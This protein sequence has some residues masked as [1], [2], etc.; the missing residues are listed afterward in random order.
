MPARRPFG[1]GRDRRRRRPGRHRPAA[2][3]VLRR[4]VSGPIQ[5]G[6][7]RPRNGVAGPGAD[8][9]VA[10]VGVAVGTGF[11]VVVGVAPADAPPVARRPIRQR[12]LGRRSGHWK[13]L[14][15]LP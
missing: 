5:N 6:A 8:A 11:G 14:S 10:G 4:R 13:A 12:R 7:L 2:V 15:F 3:A 9:G 1:G